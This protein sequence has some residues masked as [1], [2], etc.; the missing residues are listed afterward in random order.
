[1]SNPMRRIED[2]LPYHYRE[3]YPLFITFL[4]KYYEWM[5][6]KNLSGDEISLLRTDTSWISTDINKYIETGQSRYIGISVDAAINELNNV[7]SPG[8]ASDLITNNIS[9]NITSDGFVDI[10]NNEVIDSNNLQLGVLGI[11]RDI[12]NR[13]FA[14]M[15]YPVIEI[16]KFSLAPIDQVLMISLLKHLSA[17]KGT[18]Q[19]I[20]LFFNLFFNEDVQIYHPKSDIAVI[21][22]NFILDGTDVMRDDKYFDEYTYVIVVQS[23]LDKYTDI[24]NNI[25]KKIIHPSGFNVVLEYLI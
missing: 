11:N 5:Y 24:F 7:P 12:I 17:I 6:R 16:G 4:K 19:S 23:P 18:E 15:G 9:L 1:M 8:T 3:E 10:N 25:Y 13:R 22:D 2:Q 14:T 20:K 21:D